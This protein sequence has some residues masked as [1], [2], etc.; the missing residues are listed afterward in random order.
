MS[1]AARADATAM[2]DLLP[3][4]EG[5]DLFLV[6]FRTKTTSLLDPGAYAIRFGQVQRVGASVKKPY[7]GSGLSAGK[8]SKASVSGKGT[9]RIRKS[10]GEVAERASTAHAL[11]ISVILTQQFWKHLDMKQS[12]STTLIL[13]YEQPKQM[14]CVLAMGGSVAMGDKTSWAAAAKRQRGLENG[15]SNERPRGTPA[16]AI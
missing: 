14:H 16:I 8:R 13:S 12:I 15:A 2:P 1:N 7:I 6:Q 5:E 4:G 3:S 9:A 11:W 10:Y